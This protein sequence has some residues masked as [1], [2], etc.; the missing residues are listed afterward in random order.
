MIEAMND[1]TNLPKLTRK[2]QVFVDELIA[3]PKQSATKAALKAYS[4]KADTVASAVASENLRKPSIM[5][6][7]ADHAAKAEMAVTEIMTYSLEQGRES[8]AYAG[9]GLAAA[10]DVLDRVH[11]KATQKVEVQSQ[12][13]IITID[14][15][16]QSLPNDVIEESNA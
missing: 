8:P 3:N 5:Q 13:V 6:W 7:L 2:Q 12:A 9:V 16:A 4:T 15:S 11:G 14:L 1:S 10:K